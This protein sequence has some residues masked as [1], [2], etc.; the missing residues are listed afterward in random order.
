MTVIDSAMDSIFFS[1]NLEPIKTSGQSRYLKE[2]YKNTFM[3]ESMIQ[4]FTNFFK[5]RPVE[6]CP[7][8]YKLMLLVLVGFG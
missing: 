8:L 3:S 6:Q 5:E 2:A 7:I 4:S 1:S